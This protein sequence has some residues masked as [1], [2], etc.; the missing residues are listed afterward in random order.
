MYVFVRVLLHSPR[1]NK[2]NHK[3]EQDY[4]VFD[5]R[6]NETRGR[7]YHGKFVLAVTQAANH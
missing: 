4:R 2:N 5:K 1:L 3:P 6:G 7:N